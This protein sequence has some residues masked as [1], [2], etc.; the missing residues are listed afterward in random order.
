MTPPKGLGVRRTRL[1][2]R[3]AERV[4]RSLSTGWGAAVPPKGDTRSNVSGS[5]AYGLVDSRSPASVLRGLPAGFERA[6]PPAGAAAAGLDE[7][8]GTEGVVGVLVRPDRGSPQP[9][10]AWPM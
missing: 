4:A 2:W 5:V 6:R 1:S 7:L 9:Q 8:V 3:D 10:A